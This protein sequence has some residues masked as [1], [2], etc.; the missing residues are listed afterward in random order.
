M[1]GTDRNS[2]T[3]AQA[4][5]DSG[6]L[7]ESRISASTAPSTKPSTMPGAASSSVSSTE[8]NVTNVEMHY[9]NDHSIGR[10]DVLTSQPPSDFANRIIH[11]GANY[12]LQTHVS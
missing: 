1:S 2:H 3:N 5:D 4:T 10:S 9:P 6:R 12:A 8:R 11:I 7:G